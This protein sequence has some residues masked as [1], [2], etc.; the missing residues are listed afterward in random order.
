LREQYWRA[1]VA[2]YWIVDARNSPVEFQVLRRG[3]RGYS[4]V[5][6]QEGWQRSTMLGL[7]FR[8]LEQTD[9]AGNPDYVLQTR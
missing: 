6:K 8:L 9:A 1:E 7:S 2:E 4:A 3:P 5:R